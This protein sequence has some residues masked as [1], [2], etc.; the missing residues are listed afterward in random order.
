M[1]FAK[2][3]EKPHYYYQQFAKWGTPSSKQNTSV[4]ACSKIVCTTMSSNDKTNYK[5]S[6]PHLHN[7]GASGPHVQ[8]LALRAH[9]QSIKPLPLSAFKHNRVS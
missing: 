2:Y 7:P 1:Y 8:V 3:T 5:E 4:K 6:Y 9:G